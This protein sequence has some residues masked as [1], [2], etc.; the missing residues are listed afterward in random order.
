[1]YQVSALAFRVLKRGSRIRMHYI[2]IYEAGYRL[3]WS[4]V[5]FF[6]LAN[7]G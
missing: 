3:S 1:M 4:T 2:I 7:L 5:V 6:S